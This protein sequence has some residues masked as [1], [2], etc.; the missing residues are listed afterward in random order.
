MS[1]KDSVFAWVIGWVTMVIG[2]FVTIF[3]FWQPSER[4]FHGLVLFLLGFILIVLSTAFF[5][6]SN[7]VKR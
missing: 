3:S 7:A 2:A 6:I 5:N 4:V 1:A